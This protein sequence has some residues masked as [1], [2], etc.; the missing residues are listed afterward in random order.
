MQVRVEKKRENEKIVVAKMIRIYCKGH[1]HGNELCEKCQRVLDYAQQRSDKCPFMA[2]KTFCSNCQVHCYSLDMRARIKEVMRYSGP[3]MI[4]HNPLLTI[5][6]L[7][8]SKQEKQR[9]QNKSKD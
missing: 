7:R 1:H 4:I 3:R 8:E 9:I 6:H 2:N 5:R